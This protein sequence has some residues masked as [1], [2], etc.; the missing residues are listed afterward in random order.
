MFR[1]EYYVHLYVRMYVC[2][3]AC[4]Y[5]RMYVCMCPQCH[6]PSDIGV[7]IPKRFLLRMWN[8]YGLPLVL[9]KL[10]KLL[11]YRMNNNKLQAQS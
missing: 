8:R 2:M 7:D 3:Y 11:F 5:V 6:L 4:M 10:L 1:H 9:N